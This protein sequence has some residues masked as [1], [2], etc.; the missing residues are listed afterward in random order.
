M[1]ELLYL[2]NFP[3]RVNI[4]VELLY[5]IS[6]TINKNRWKMILATYLVSGHTLYGT[7]ET[8]KDIHVQGT[9]FVARDT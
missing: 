5:E 4:F 1:C 2:F 6:F 8:F 7:F 9:C 3:L